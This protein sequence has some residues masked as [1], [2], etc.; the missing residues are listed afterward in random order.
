MKVK[1]YNFLK[2]S[3]LG[4]F[5]V[6]LNLGVSAQD[7]RVTGKV[8]NA[9]DGQAIPGASIQVKG[10]TTGTSADAN[11][12]YSVAVKSANDVLVITS[13]GYK[14][15]EVRVGSQS[16]INVSLTE[17]ANALSEVLVTGYGTQQ[18]KDLTGGVSVI[19]PKELLAVPS[20]SFQSQLEGR[21]AGV[22]VGGTGEPGS[23]ASVRIRGIGTFGDND[24]L[25]II[26]GVPR[27]GNR[28]VDINPND[29]ESI[30]V[31]KDASAAAIYGSRAGNGV[32]IITTKKGKAGEAK[33]EYTG[34]YGIQKAGRLVD[35]LNAQEWATQRFQAIANA[36]L[37]PE[38]NIAALYGTGATPVLPDYI[39]PVGAREGDPRVNPANYNAD[40]NSSNFN[41]ITRANKTGTDWQ[42]E[43]MQDAPI[44]E[45]NMTFSGGTD[46]SRYAVSFN[47]FNQEGLLKHTYNKRYSIRANTEF[48]IKKYLTIGE[49]L[50]VSHNEDIRNIPNGPG[51]GSV[52]QGSMRAQPIMPVF[53]ITG[54]YAGAKG[55]LSNA[56]NPYAA[57]A[58][59]KD[60]KGYGLNLFG[61]VYAD[62]NLGFIDDAAGTNIFKNLSFKTQIGLD[63][64]YYHYYGFGYRN[65][66]AAEPNSSNSFY[67]GGGYGAG[68]TWYNV[69]TFDKQFGNDHHLKIYGGSEAILN[70]GRNSSGN[71]FNYFV[72]SKNFWTLSAGAPAGQQANSDA[73]NSALYSLFARAEYSLMDKYLFNATIRR[74]GSSV[75]GPDNRY[76][77]FPSAAFAWRISKED[78]L[79]DLT[80]VD[81]MKL[82]VGWGQIGNQ[83]IDGAN[84]YSTFSSGAGFSAYD[85]G[86]TSTS[87]LLGFALNRIG[88]TASK[89]ETTTST[90]LG[91]DVTLFNRKIDVAL[92]VWARKTSDILY[93]QELPGTASSATA[94]SVNI[95]DMENRGVDLSVNYRGSA[96]T[97]KLKYNIGL[98]LGTYRNK[99]LRVGENDGTFFTGGGSRIGDISRSL[100]DNPMAMFY[101]F[102]LDGFFNTDAEVRAAPEQPGGK[103]VG[104]WRL[105]DINNDKVVDDNDKTFIGNPHPKFTYGLNFDVN[106]GNWDFNV[107]F[108]GVQGNDIFN[109]TRYWIDFEVFN[110]NRSKEALYDSWTPQNTNASLPRLDITDQVSN[111]FV[112][113]YYIEDGSYFRAKNLSLGYKLRLGK[114]G[115]VAR[116][117]GQATNLF[118]VTKYRGYNPAFTT[119][120]FGGGA[121]RTIGIDY[122]YYPV[123]KQFIVGVNLNF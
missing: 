42:R 29:I 101:G 2:S 95:G 114:S 18:K 30:Q 20:G 93:Q 123:V 40:I 35:V 77:T 44:M 85:I 70:Q 7:R 55:I 87:P 86:G 52:I 90:N 80:W 24:P 121:D 38:G 116:I 120:G 108:Q 91:L 107:F 92:D 31:M 45:H 43:I 51:E 61:N 6:L 13:I 10:T 99:I 32:I 37:K 49:N 94:P 53:D 21:A 79:K 3:L 60:N 103:A 89:W 12:N 5:V 19:K 17:D 105:A 4:A 33:V 63:Y 9:S 48:K 56:S 15:T 67:E 88:N 27:D 111:G 25:Y 57:L 59:N 98:N 54:F 72:D 65:I 14:S 69:L 71:R 34:Y 41:L 102:K 11:G 78:F 83:K 75:F 23:P 118:T 96:M 82:R 28:Q 112:H 100:K 109:Y 39:F 46:K 122:G 62:L 68:Y 73:Y 36:G 97:S 66:E 1:F 117:Y 64:G 50:K 113:S 58:R 119:A 110:G 74:D 47:Y 115:N 22:V 16:V 106:Y 84:A 8:S 26:D 81:D 76:A 104:R